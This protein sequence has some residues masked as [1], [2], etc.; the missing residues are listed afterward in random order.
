MRGMLVVA[1]KLLLM[2]TI[3]HRLEE[4]TSSSGGH[5][6]WRGGEF[7]EV[8]VEIDRLR[9]LRLCLLLLAAKSLWG[10]KTCGPR[11]QSPPIWT[12]GDSF[13]IVGRPPA[14]AWMS[15]RAPRC[16]CC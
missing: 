9:R 10:G 3:E 13:E 5:W 1:L 7:A 16:C 11:R 15:N 2:V 6:R 8:A 4:A 12:Q 14:P